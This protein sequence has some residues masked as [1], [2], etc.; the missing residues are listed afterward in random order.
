MSMFLTRVAPSGYF[1]ENSNRNQ[2]LNM[3]GMK[4]AFD[5][6]PIPKVFHDCTC[7]GLARIDEGWV[8]LTCPP[9]A[10]FSAKRKN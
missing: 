4:Y 2:W 9:K 1:K 6:L 7:P 8:G 10:R 3:N 5:Q